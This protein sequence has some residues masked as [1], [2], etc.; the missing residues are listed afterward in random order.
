[1]HICMPYCCSH[2][3][4][5]THTFTHPFTYNVYGINYNIQTYY[6]CFTLSCKNLVLSD[7]YI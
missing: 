3:A 2:S 5:Y 7:I 6:L 1:M 4:F